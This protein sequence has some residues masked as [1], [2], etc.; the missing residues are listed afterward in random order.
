MLSS[1]SGA[2]RRR[3]KWFEKNPPEWGPDDIRIVLNE[4]AWARKGT[5]EATPDA[6]SPDEKGKRS[7]VADGIRDKR[8]IAGFEVLVRWESGLPVRLAQKRPPSAADGGVSYMLSVSRLPMPLLMAVFS[9]GAA[10]GQ[11]KRPQNN[12]ELAED[13][14]KLSSLERDNKDPIHADRAEWA[15]FDFGSE[16]LISF[17]NV[18]QPIELSDRV[19]IFRSQIGSL[20]VRAEFQLKP[21]V[22]KGKLEL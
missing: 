13:V 10:G 5:L 9:N 11:M 7:P 22:F 18:R 4:S 20:I 2:A 8:I 14:A 12:R 1:L 17:S 15:D 6:I 21:M 16:I 19:V 3:L